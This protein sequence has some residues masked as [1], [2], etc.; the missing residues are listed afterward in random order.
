MKVSYQIPSKL[1]AIPGQTRKFA[2]RM[3][4]VPTITPSKRDGWIQ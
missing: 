4:R 1:C 2:A 3:A